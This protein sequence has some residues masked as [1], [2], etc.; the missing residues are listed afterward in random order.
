MS[1]KVE[2]AKPAAGAATAT[3]AAAA[4]AG[5]KPEVKVVKKIAAPAV[6]MDGWDDF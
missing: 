2:P 1:R 3:A 5:G 6:Q 4:A